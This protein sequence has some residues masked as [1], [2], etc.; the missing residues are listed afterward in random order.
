MP[1]PD[2]RLERDLAGFVRDLEDALGDALVSV[3]LYGSAA[4]DD[5]VPGHP[6]STPWSPSAP[7]RAAS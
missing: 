4:A 5:W 1:G 7:C 2:G 3:S 6:T